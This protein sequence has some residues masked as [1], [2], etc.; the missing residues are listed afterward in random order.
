VSPALRKLAANLLRRASEEFG[1]HGC[2]DYRLG[3]DGGLSPA[4]IREV[5]ALVTTWVREFDPQA[6]EI[7]DVT[8]DWLLMDFFVAVLEEG[9]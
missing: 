9:T 4:E 2:N 5:R 3:E 8:M 7:E 1:N 6:E